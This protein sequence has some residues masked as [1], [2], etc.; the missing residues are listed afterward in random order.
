[1]QYRNKLTYFLKEGNILEL[2]KWMKAQPL[3]EQVDIAREFRSL[4]KDIFLKADMPE[5]IEQLKA[6]DAIIENYQERILDE[7]LAHL[8]VELAREEMRKR[9]IAER[10]ELIKSSKD[11]IIDCILA[12]MPN[13]QDCKVAAAHLIRYEKETG[14]YDSASW[15]GSMDDAE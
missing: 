15:R 14:T 4:M 10:H 5:Q 12:D 7:Q 8:K 9:H 2:M 1:M 6:F 11:F 13:K 3:L